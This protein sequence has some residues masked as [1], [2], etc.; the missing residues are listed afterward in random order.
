MVASSCGTVTV[1]RIVSVLPASAADGG[2]RSDWLVDEDVD[3]G[4]AWPVGENT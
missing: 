3:V 1:M 4:D 2:A